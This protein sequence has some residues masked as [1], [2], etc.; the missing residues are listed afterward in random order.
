M[1]KAQGEIWFYI[2]TREEAEEQINILLSYTESDIVCIS[3]EVSL[4]RLCYPLNILCEITV[5]IVR[6]MCYTSNTAKN[7]F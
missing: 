3:A 6:K 4:F 5:Q 2:A 1:K 7:S